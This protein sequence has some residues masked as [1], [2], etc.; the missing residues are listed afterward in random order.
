MLKREYDHLVKEMKDKWSPVEKSLQGF[1]NKGVLN[2]LSVKIPDPNNPD[3]K[4]DAII[5]AGYTN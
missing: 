2:K 1:I 4:L 5:F 3:Q